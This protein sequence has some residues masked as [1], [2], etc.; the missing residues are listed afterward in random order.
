LDAQEQA[1]CEDET[2]EGEALQAVISHFVCSYNAAVGK[3]L[4][5]AASWLRSNPDFR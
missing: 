5:P 1:R 3:G 2:K 4:Q